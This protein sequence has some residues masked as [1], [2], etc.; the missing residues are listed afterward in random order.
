MTHYSVVVYIN[1]TRFFPR[2]VSVSA[3]VGELLSFTVDVTPVAEWA[4]LPPRSH[5][6]VF[7]VDPVTESWRMLCEGEFV[8]FTRSKN[9]QGQRSRTL[10]CRGLHGY[11]EQAKYLNVAGLLNNTASVTGSL[12]DIK[13]RADANGSAV[14]T[15]PAS[16]AYDA[17]VGLT[18]IL[19]ATTG[20]SASPNQ[21]VAAVLKG[22]T[23]QTNVEAVYAV[24][25]KV[26]QK[27]YSITDTSI[28]RWVD[29]MRFVD[30]AQNG[31]NFG[32]LNA[33][34]TIGEVMRTY[35]SLLSYRPVPLL[36]PPY[37][38]PSD[39]PSADTSTTV[40]SPELMFLPTLYNTIPPACNVIYNDQITHLDG[41]VDY[42]ASCTRVVGQVSSLLLQS[43]AN[44]PLFYMANNNQGV[45]TVAESSTLTDAHM[46]THG[47]LSTH[48]RDMGIITSY[49][50]LTVEKTLPVLSNAAAKTGVVTDSGEIL[51]KYFK[52]AVRTA[53]DATQ[54]ES[55]VVSVGTIFLPYL[56]AGFTCLIED[57]DTPILGYIESITHVLPQGAAPTTNLVVSQ[58]HECFVRDGQTRTAPMA[59][60]INAAF[61]PSRVA[62]TY[63]KLFGT[64]NDQ[65]G[66]AIATMVPPAAFIKESVEDPNDETSAS[67][68]VN[69]DKL[70]SQVVAV[71]R[72]AND[73]TVTL[74]YSTPHADRLRTAS[75]GN[76]TQTLYN[77]QYRAGMSLSDYMIAHDVIPNGVD[78][79]T[80]DDASTPGHLPPAQLTT[81][82]PARGN[83]LFAAP[84]AIVAHGPGGTHGFF[85]VKVNDWSIERER[86]VK[87]IAQAIDAGLTDGTR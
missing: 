33:E 45:D 8:G 75:T 41:T 29:S 17:P 39:V 9:Q 28:T 54:G 22:M 4:I 72:Y 78:P 71:P 53:Y 65:V 82:D 47:A 66:G 24:A 35:L 18:N 6:V 77:A 87:V 46:V 23:E 38:A 5:V 55:K 10:M 14:S 43:S 50:P 60:S 21:M 81:P 76:L 73:G 64:N 61:A 80:I 36:A 30:L 69:M 52:M 19:L 20:L 25:R 32:G 7:F 62:D 68:Q 79:D 2:G 57:G 26:Y 49:V 12:V 63:T 40:I 16:D 37:Y 27:W 59:V 15:S 48:E 44:L 67:Y 11:V 86:A 31:F 34:T 1:G 70:A 84:N 3:N 42:R 58:V 56:A 85:N 74:A 83:P 51:N 13:A